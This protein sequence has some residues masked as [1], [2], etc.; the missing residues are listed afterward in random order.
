MA[1]I[2]IALDY[3]DKKSALDMAVKL[4][5]KGLWM[6][7]GMELFTRAGTDIISALKDMGYPVFLDL[8]FHDIPNTVEGAV[9]SAARLGAS[10]TTIHI[11]GGE[12]MVKAALAGAKAADAG[13][14]LTI[15]G[16]TVLTSMDQHDLAEEISVFGLELP[17]AYKPNPA[18]IALMRAQNAKN[19]GLKGIV[20]SAHETKAIK[21]A[22]GN[23]FICLNPGIRLKGGNV[24]DQ[25]RVMTPAKAVAAGADFLVIGRAVTGAADPI[26]VVGEIFEEITGG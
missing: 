10:L 25:K 21:Q 17:A 8:K 20:C 9:A 15:L 19:W 23:D 6:K 24:Q 13:Q 3:P 22:C 5:D 2:V 7:V 18:Q 1:K 26:A 11:S 14:A 16:V 4:K 12:N